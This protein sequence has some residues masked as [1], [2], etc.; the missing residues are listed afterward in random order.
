MVLVLMLTTFNGIGQ[1]TEKH[2]FP[3]DTLATAMTKQLYNSI[4]NLSGKGIMI[5]H[6]DALSY[7]V[8]WKKG[9]NRSD[10][11]DVTG[12][13]PAVYGWDIGG[14]ELGW[15]ANL[16]SVPFDQMRDNIILAF[17]N[18]GVNTISWHVF[19]PVTS[20]DSW[21]DTKLPNKTVSMILPGGSHH[22][23]FIAQL[24][25]VA[26]FFKTLNTKEGE[27]IPIVFR[28]WHEHSGN[29]FWWGAKHC[30]KEEY[31][32]LYRFTVSYLRTKHALHQLLMAY[33]PDV[34]FTDEDSYLERY[35]GD[36]VVDVIGVDDYNSLRTN[37]PTKL[38]NH[39]EIIS[40]IATKKNK[41]S[42]FT[43]TGITDFSGR[44][45]FM[46]ELFPCLDHSQ[47]TR[48]VSWVLFWRNHNEK[49]FYVP[50]PSNPAT[51]DF[52]EFCNKEYILLNN[53]L[54][55]LYRVKEVREL[56]IQ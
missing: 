14:L 48:S 55:D 4:C 6:Q 50:Y 29:W 42:A 2:F 18:G 43:E 33:S 12:S 26:A 37:Q 5:G 51:V 34:G 11:K 3:S 41:I 32:Q 24:D 52:I 53:D 56:K 13:H 1:S 20:L 8:H 39:L 17:E 22:K 10:I 23:A 44:N 19:N 21:A 9:E 7:G 15:E 36:D 27:P 40:A 49:Q 25:A 54:P 35:P 46:H 28:P 30:S 45:Y 16:D 47:L 31:I 38:I